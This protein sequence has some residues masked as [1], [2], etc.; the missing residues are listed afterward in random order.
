MATRIEKILKSAR[1][2]LADK[3]GERWTD[4]DLIS[5]LDEGHK[6]LCRQTQ[7]LNGRADI[8]LTI[9]DAYF[10]LP[11]DCWMLTRVT[12]E[13]K[14]LP[15]ISHNDL[16][17]NT[18]A[19]LNIDFGN[20]VAA[21]NWEAVEGLPQA[22][23]YD[24]R[25]LLEGKIFPI[26]SAE[27][28]EF[29][30]DF[31]RPEDRPIEFAGDELYGTVTSIDKPEYSLSSDFGVTTDLFDPSIKVEDF[32][33]DFGLVTGI[34]EVNAVLKCY[35]VANP[36][37]LVDINSEL[38]TPYMFDTALKFYLVGHA[39]LNDLN[40]EYQQ[41]GAQQLQFYQRELDIADK[42]SVRSGTR[43]G[44]FETNYRGAF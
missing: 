1:V 31:I 38:A 30:Y 16:D 10:T 28:S 23:I 7:I 4:A 18:L 11:D 9:G 34:S 20:Q 42:T 22:I 36:A 29:D 19:R 37:D 33:S 27:I 32:E 13:D 43:A 17:I 3:Q 26:P 24:K 2:T 25:N 12:Y 41:K 15:L 6:D 35:Y 21:G 40:Q 14:V 8:T 44:Q 5:I 39:F